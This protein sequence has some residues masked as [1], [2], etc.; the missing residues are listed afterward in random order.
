MAALKLV[1]DNDAHPIPPPTRPPGALPDRCFRETCTACGDCI[2]VCPMGS[3]TMDATGFPGIG[4]PETCSLCGLCA[5]VCMT[6]AIVFTHE[7]LRGLQMVLA[8]ECEPD[9][10]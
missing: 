1:V 8:L 9:P 4:A 7:T 3:I 5:D 10:T 6:G 2:E